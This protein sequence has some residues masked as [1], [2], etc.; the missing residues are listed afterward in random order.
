MSETTKSVPIGLA[1]SD[2]K[3]QTKFIRSF[4][5]LIAG[6]VAG[7]I[8]IRKT[9][10]AAVGHADFPIGCHANAMGCKGAREVRSNRS[11]ASS[12]WSRALA[13]RSAG[14]AGPGGIDAR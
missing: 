5:F 14:E 8:K 2:P 11:S 9:F 6:A 7:P 12:S 3:V 4:T 1:P 13:S 10:F